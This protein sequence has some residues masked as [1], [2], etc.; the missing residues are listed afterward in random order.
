[1]NALKSQAESNGWRCLADT[2]SGYAARYT[3]MCGAEHCFVRQGTYILYSQPGTLMC[4]ACRQ[5]AKQ[6]RLGL[7]RNA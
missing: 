7:D 4:P 6:K 1:M 2:W 5:D 3:F